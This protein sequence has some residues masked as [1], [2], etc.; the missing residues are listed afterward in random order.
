MYSGSRFT[1]AKTQS[2]CP[3]EPLLAGFFKPAGAIW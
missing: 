3:A 2:G 1:P